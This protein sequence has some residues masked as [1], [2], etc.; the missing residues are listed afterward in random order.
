MW[1]QAT[2]CYTNDKLIVNLQYQN[3]ER[4]NLTHASE[5][6]SKITKCSQKSSFFAFCNDILLC[7]EITGGAIGDCVTDSF[8]LTAPG[9]KGSPTICGLN[10]GQHSM[11][12][13][14]E[15]LSFL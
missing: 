4:N 14:N 15:T 7:I 5:F 13:F 10:T 1:L 6:E 12:Y 9:N 3:F 8:V 2:K 11:Y